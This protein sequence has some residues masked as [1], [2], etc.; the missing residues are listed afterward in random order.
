MDDKLLN[1]GALAFV[2]DAVMTLQVREYLVNK[3]IT[4]LKDLQEK[5]S[6]MV[7]AKAQAAFSKTIEE[8]LTEEEMEIFKRGRNF[9]SNS[10]A[11]N[12]SVLDYRHATGVEALWGYWY[13][14]NNE[15]RL[16]E[17]CDRLIAFNESNG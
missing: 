10:T 13:L 5:T 4:H 17:M 9:K 16:K 1:G 6:S 15:D 11:K 8:D 3:G 12:A 2:G 14:E 7:S